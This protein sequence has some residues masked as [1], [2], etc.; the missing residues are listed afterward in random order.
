[1]MAHSKTISQTR[2]LHNRFLYSRGTADEPFARASLIGFI[3]RHLDEVDPYVRVNLEQYLTALHS[4]FIQA[5]GELYL[6]EA[7]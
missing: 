6:G 2:A 4:T 1:M 5:A 7:A 3:R